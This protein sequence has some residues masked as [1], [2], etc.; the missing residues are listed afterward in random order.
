MKKMRIL[1]F[2]TLIIS[3]LSF[4]LLNA[5]AAG[6]V[7]IK[8]SDFEAEPGEVFSTIISVDSE[9]KVEAFETALLFDTDDVSIT[10]RNVYTVGTNTEF[11]VSEEKYVAH[12]Y[13]DS[14][15]YKFAF[16]KENGDVSSTDIESVSLENYT[17][18]SY[19]A[20]SLVE[21]DYD[22]IFKAFKEQYGIILLCPEILINVVDNQIIVSWT[23]NN[24]EIDGTEM[25]MLQFKAEDNLAEGKYTSW[26][27][28]DE[29]YESF[30]E[31]DEKSLDM[32][33]DIVPLS[34]YGYGDINFDHKV[35]TR[36]ALRARQHYLKIEGKI[37]TGL[38]FKLG[39]VNFDSKVNTRDALYIQKYKIKLIDTIGNRFK[40]T[41][42]DSDGNVYCVKSVAV[43]NSV[44]RIP[45]VPDKE[46][47]SKGV[48]SLSADE[49]I[50]PDYTNI[51]HNVNVYAMYDSES[52]TTDAMEFYKKQLTK[53]YYSGD[54]PTNLSSDQKLETKLYYQDGQ[55]ATIIWSSNCNYVLNS[56]TGAFTKPTYPQNLTLSASII[57]YD[58]NNKIE[59]EGKIDFEY[60][61]PGEY[62]TPTKAS[63]E[64]FLKFYFTD[65]T[66]DKYRIN[67]DA[68]LITK[69]NN[70]VIPVEGSMYDNF[71]IR[72][73][74]YQNVNG[75]LKPISQVKRTTS[76]QTNDYVAVVTFNGKPLE[77]DGKIYIDGVEVTPIEEME[78]K[79][80]IINKIAANMGTL[81]T[82][83]TELWNDDSVYGTSV[84]WETGA[85]DIAYV[86][87]NVI[88]LKDNAVSGSTL[89]LNARVSYE[90]DGGTKEFVLSYNLTVS[91]NNTII[92]APEN[93]DPGLYKAIKMELE[94]NLGYRGDLTSAA[95]A[96]VKFVNL[97]LSKYQK[98]A[99]EY[100]ELRVKYPQQYPNDDYPEILSFKGLS[101][102]KNLRTLNISGIHVTDKSM[103]QIATLSYLEAFIARGC[104]LDNL[105]DGGTPTLKNASKLSL[106][107]LTDNNFTTLDSVFAED[108]RY[109]SLREVYLSKNK[110]QD[111]NA[112]S[113]APMM[114]YLS[115]ADNGLT[116]EGT[117]SI[118][119]FP[120]LLY[121]SL[122][123]NKI[124]SVE[125]LTGLKYLKE[126]RLQN[127]DLSNVNALKRLV[128]LEIL[129]LGHNKIKDIGNLNTLTQLQILYAN[130]NEIFDISA[131]REL[132]K[133]EAIN[134]SNNKISSLSVLGNFK[135][136]LTEIYAE[137]N[138]LTDFSF[139]NGAGNLHILMLA[140][141][142]TELAQDNMTT[143]L[144]G[145]PEME[146]LTLSGIRLNDLSFLEPMS[147]LVRL[148]V[149]KCGLQSFS[150]ETDNIQLIADKYATLKALN[151]SNNDFSDSESEIL[152]LRNVTLLKVLY[153]D[154][155]CSNLDAYTLTY[156]MTELK[157]ISMEN[158]GITSLNWLY[159]FNDLVYVDLAGNNVS[160]VNLESQISNASL[161]TIK[162]LYLDTNV[163]CVFENAFRVSDFNVEKLSL[164]GVKVGKMEYMPSE[165][166]KI[167]Y[168][169]LDNTGI[170]N[171]AGEDPELVDIYSIEKYKTLDTL[172]IS[173][174][175]TD[176]SV[177]KNMPSVKTLYAVGAVDSKR[178]YKNNLYGLQ[179]LYNN[180]VTCYLYDKN[181]E[182]EPLAK[183]E[184][185]AILD[186][187]KDFSCDVTVAAEQVI[188]D[189]NPFIIDT[190]NDYTI[191]WSVSNS[192]NYEIKNNYLCVKSY[193]G[194][195]DETLTITASIKVYPDQE[196]VTRDFIINTTILRATPEYYTVSNNGYAENLTRSSSFGY[197]IKTRETQTDGFSVPVK[198]VEDA[199][200]FSFTAYGANGDNIPYDQIVDAMEMN[201]L[202][203]DGDTNG[204]LTKGY[205][206]TI[207]NGAPLGSKFVINAGIYHVTSTGQKVYDVS[208][209]TAPVTVASRTFNV[210]FVMDG[211]TIVDSNGMDRSETSFVEDA[212]IFEGLTYSKK[213]YTFAGWYKDADFN[214]LFSKDG[215]NAKMPS[216]NITL[217]AKWNALSYN[218]IL[219]ANGGEVNQKSIAAL[220]DV[221]IGELPVPTRTYYTFDGWFTS[222]DGGEPVT[223]ASKFARTE[224]LT[225]YAHW[226]LN[227]FVVTFDANGGVCETE[228]LRAYCGKSLGELPVP[229]RDY[230]TFTGWYTTADGDTRITGA[231][232][233]DVAKDMIFYA[234]WVIN[235]TSDWIKSS[236]A[237]ADAQIVA[238]KWSYNL[239]SY[240]SNSA[241]SLSGWTK[242]DTKRTSWGSW[243]S[244]A[245][246]NPN[247]G[248]RNVEWRA[249][250]DHTEYHYYRWT[251]GSGSYTYQYNSSYWLEENWFTYVLPVSKFGTSIGY[252]DG[253]DSGP[254]LWTRADYSGNRSVDKT[255]SRDIYRDEWRYQDPIYTYYYYKDE[256][257]E[258]TS[259]P[260]SGEVSNIVEWVQYI[261]KTV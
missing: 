191:D 163:P 69:I 30:A 3:I 180:G 56:T 64:D 29:N 109:G 141:N 157:Y 253:K 118:A 142:S 6:S 73:S 119:N 145:L 98:Q 183:K 237:P 83:N 187:I 177:V 254:Y 70:T 139:I 189:N 231:E 251:N 26:L 47:Y 36:D 138:K 186:L 63:V 208:G 11:A 249:V 181:T 134:V 207:K 192:K 188:S 203:I 150:G 65:N 140:G 54:M 136:T 153:A 76:K 9:S 242:Y 19:S 61:V 240:T 205:T 155:I 52:Y 261:P 10:S 67:Y 99:E 241:S 137:N 28:V 97:D 91:C 123:N 45:E 113:R 16:F 71:E 95:L 27:S 161:K 221:E 100:N 215:K 96:N 152:K 46:G 238:Q 68:K 110:L 250:Y 227:S 228:S 13:K 166:E 184:G 39:D 120:Y 23:P 101:Y 121:L 31:F 160:D 1:F 82:N 258:A 81:A 167:K 146:V 44:V 229:T 158:C 117:A 179:E 195:E 80:F 174:N 199:I 218:V 236:E 171:L 75:E 20:F 59:A 176:I 213:G 246:W 58:S 106:L 226:T 216:E 193:S 14:D 211:G 18:E 72:L 12:S 114:T 165:L 256:S 130:D 204:L 57:S 55:Y 225:L 173:N 88:K 127:N 42:Y 87:N 224:N 214:D 252:V 223:S 232:S 21:K 169:N 133:L 2:I 148:D 112:L 259:Y 41:F 239:R 125:N 206:I 220:S 185:K 4:S 212:M 38:R 53:M 86:E 32:G 260:T 131:L 164:Q 234:H 34:I 24:P 154:N 129:Y 122:A 198:P 17:E 103:N 48:W 90:V 5:S 22:S 25:F 244:W 248:V 255:W 108:T 79:N 149:E 33:F 111:I 245:T 219:D 178:F 8:A 156:S 84:T 15:G 60:A 135:S 217:Y 209:I 190:I 230:Y 35:D 197:I 77:G 132:T 128:N 94:S 210:S 89:P 170:S 196:P 124:D 115:L 168:L 93:M 92:K 66:D 162:E 243:S 116:T 233:Y 172:D 49:Y 175:E 200:E 7:T 62:I 40:V 151:I 37:L 144:S 102:C 51:Q 194:I 182:Y 247:N 74:W 105:T 222:P 50:E 201:T 85:S 159:K 202:R 126:L 107:D 43:G 235:P 257:I 78:I 147:K 143:W 104:G